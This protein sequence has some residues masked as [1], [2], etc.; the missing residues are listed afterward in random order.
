MYK[1]PQ[2]KQNGGNIVETS[3]KELID[4]SSDDDASKA[5]SKTEKNAKETESVSNNVSEEAPSQ[6]PST[7]ALK[8]EPVA[9]KQETV[10]IHAIS[11]RMHAQS[12]AKFAKIR[13]H[14]VH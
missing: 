14:Y 7:V 9:L 12:Y 2:Y 4:I 10:C 3:D 5:E 1:K 11:T 6:T 13:V 8:S